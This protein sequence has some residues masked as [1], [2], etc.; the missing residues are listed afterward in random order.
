MNLRQRIHRSRAHDAWVI[1]SC[2]VV[3]HVQAVRFHELLAAIFVRLQ[4]RTVARLVLP[5]QAT[6]VVAGALHGQ[7][8][9]VRG[10]PHFADV[11]QVVTAVVV[12]VATLVHVAFRGEEFVGYLSEG[13]SYVV[14]L[15]ADQ[16]LQIESAFAA[17]YPDGV[18]PRGGGG[19]GHECVQSQGRRHDGRAGGGRGEQLAPARQVH[20]AYFV[21]VWREQDFIR[22]VQQVV[23]DGCNAPV[24]IR[25]H[26]AVGIVGEVVA[27]GVPVVAFLAVVQSCRTDEIGHTDK[28]AAV[29]GTSGGNS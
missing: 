9:A 26:V 14:V 21:P 11:A 19:P 1:P 28:T 6:G 24:F 2:M 7:C 3:V 25:G 15:R 29:T 4:A 18:P 23:L 16:V 10:F 27:P 5:R 13:R 8:N 12:I 22:Q 20:V 17:F